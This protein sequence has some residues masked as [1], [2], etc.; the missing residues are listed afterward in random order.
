MVTCSNCNCNY[1]MSPDYFIVHAAYEK[2]KPT[3]IKKDYEKYEKILESLIKTE[4]FCITCCVKNTIIICNNSNIP[5][6]EYSVG[7]S[8]QLDKS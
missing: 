6:R 8:H 4:L 2:I 7:Y 5:I 3:H 1:I